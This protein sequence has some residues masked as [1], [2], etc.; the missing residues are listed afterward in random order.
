MILIETISSTLTSVL[1]F[2]LL[3]LLF[4][5]IVTL[6]GMEFF[7]YKVHVDNIIDENPCSDCKV[8]PRLN[9]DTFF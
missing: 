2:F 7:A 9:F 1:S 3:L 4:I 5:F 6:L 8:S